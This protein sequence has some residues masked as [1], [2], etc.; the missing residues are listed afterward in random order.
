MGSSLLLPWQVRLF[1]L[2]LLLRSNVD[3][4]ESAFVV[5]SIKFSKSEHDE[6]A[7]R[8]KE[9]GTADGPA[10]EF[11]QSMSTE[12][13]AQGHLVESSGNSASGNAGANPV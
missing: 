10:A 7:K 2:D 13:V 12:S 11:H 3:T 1:Y 5:A 4:F 6:K 9:T 8:D